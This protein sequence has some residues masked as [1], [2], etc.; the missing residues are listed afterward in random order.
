MNDMIFWVFFYVISILLYEYCRIYFA[1]KI[2]FTILHKF[3][4]SINKKQSA[5]CEINLILFYFCFSI[6]VV[7]MYCSYI[8]YCGLVFFSCSSKNTYFFYKYFFVF[9]YL[10]SVIIALIYIIGVLYFF[11]VA[12]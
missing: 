1:Y 8:Y 9:S 12:Q 6:L 2:Y 5:I 4:I 7:S 10:Y 3:Y 11:H